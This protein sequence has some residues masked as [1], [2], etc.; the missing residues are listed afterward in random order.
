[1]TR[2]S[3]SWQLAEVLLWK[4]PPAVAECLYG[5]EP[6]ETVERS[7]R[8]FARSYDDTEPYE[9]DI[10]TIVQQVLGSQSPAPLTRSLA[11]RLALLAGQSWAG[12]VPYVIAGED[13]KA[14]LLIWVMSLC[15]P[16]WEEAPGWP[17]DSRLV[18]GIAGHALRHRDAPVVPV[19][20]ALTY[21]VACVAQSGDF[22]LAT[23]AH[24]VVS[25]AGA[26]PP[27]ALAAIRYWTDRATSSDREDVGWRLDGSAR[28]ELPDK[29][30]WLAHGDRAP[31]RTGEGFDQVRREWEVACD[32]IG[33]WLERG[34]STH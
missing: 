33:Q 18:G 17:C 2:G 10:S 19:L 9:Q 3:K 22:L 27:L 7:L 5:V 25:V 23:L 30:L 12:A 15:H 34:S 32:A 14:A 26:R 1:V 24:I 21:D 29:I 20:R 6:L 31:A 16:L 8:L 11:D 4:Y 13:S 28:A